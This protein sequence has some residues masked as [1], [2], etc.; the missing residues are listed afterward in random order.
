[1]FLL[2]QSS[3][4]QSFKMV[5]QYRC[6]HYYLLFLIC[7]PLLGAFQVLLVVKVKNPPASAGNVKRC[8]F[9]PWVRKIPWRRAWEPTP[10]FLSGESWWTQEPGR[11]QSMGSQS[12]T[13]LSDSA[14]HST[15]LCLKEW[16]TDTSPAE[17]LHRMCRITSECC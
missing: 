1:M 10:V 17:G 12:Q 5:A 14:R 16:D 7:F 4:L 2:L 9:D 3:S 8:R 13:R 6:G 15:V 11:L